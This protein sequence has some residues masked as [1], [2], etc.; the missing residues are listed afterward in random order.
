[1]SPPPSLLPSTTNSST[2]DDR[3]ALQFCTIQ[4]EFR[5]KISSSFSDFFSKP[6]ADMV[7]KKL[8]ENV[9]IALPN[10]PSF[11]IIESLYKMEQHKL[12]K[13]CID[14]LKELSEYLKKT[15]LYL[16]QIVFHG[17]NSYDHHFVE[18]FTNIIMKEIHQ[19]EKECLADLK[20][21]LEIEA[22]IFT[23]N[24]YYMDTVNKIK[25]EFLNYDEL[26]KSNTNSSGKKLRSTINYNEKRAA[27][28]VQIAVFA[29]CKV[30]EKRMVDQIS[31]LCYYFLIT[32]CALIIDLK[33]STTFSWTELHRI[34]AEPFEQKQKRDALELSIR[35]YEAAL[36]LGERQI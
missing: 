5:R 25:R 21:Q 35:N 13:P 27:F 24:S 23:L 16:L 3:I 19:A 12:Q 26:T 22:R 4:K 18:C 31:Q 33:L 2:L 34:M 28:D 20:Q 10:F 11:H 36:C 29:Y 8:D 14:L 6:Y 9:G 7:F 1:A 17:D 15:L 32:K 30:V